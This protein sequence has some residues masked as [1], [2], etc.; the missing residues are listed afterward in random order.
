MAALQTSDYP[1]SWKQ[2]SSADC[3][4]CAAHA[5]KLMASGTP[6]AAAIAMATKAHKTKMAGGK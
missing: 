5:G 4:K 6:K 2:M 3:A 1:A